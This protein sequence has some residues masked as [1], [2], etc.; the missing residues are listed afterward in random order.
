[1]EWKNT[2]IV[3]ISKVKNPLVPSNYRPISLCQTN[4]KIVASM[5]VN[6]L[7]KC[8][9][10]MISEE[11]M[12]FIPDRSISE[13]CL[14]AHEVF[15]KF[16]IS[17]NKKGLMA[18][19]LDM[20]QTYDSMGWPTLCQIL[21]WYGFPTFFSNVL[22]ECVVNVSSLKQRGQVLGIRVSHGVPKITHLLYADDVLVFSQV[23]L[24]I[25]KAL[26]VIVEDFCK[27]TGQRINA[28]KS[29]ILYGKAV[30]HHLKKKIARVIGFK[31]VK[32]MSYL[33]VRIYLNLLRMADFQELLSQVMERLNTWGK[34]SL[35]MGEALY[36]I[37][38]M[39][40][41]VCI[42][43]LGGEICKPRDI[44]GLGVHS[45]MLRIGSLRARLTCNYLHKPESLFHRTVRAKYGTDVMNGSHMKTSSSAWKILLDGGRN[46]R[47]VVKWKVGNDC[48]INV[49]KDV[50]LLDKCMDMWPT[51]AN[52]AALE[53]MIVQH[54]I[55]DGSWNYDLLQQ[56]FHTDLVLLISQIQIDSNRVEDQ[57]ELLSMFSGKTISA[58]SYEN[59]MKYRYPDDDDGYGNGLK[60]LKLNKKV[61]ISWWRLS[62]SAIPT[63]YFLKYRRI[64]FNDQCARG[65]QMFE[66]YE[67]IMV[68]CRY[69][70][71][72]IVKLRDWEITKAF[73]RANLT[74]PKGD[75]LK[76]DP[77]EDNPLEDEDFKMKCLAFKTCII[78]Y[79]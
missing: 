41:G 78:Q 40:R 36:G 67:H 62:K 48:K 14:L 65:C 10:T 30:R 49:L 59:L 71:D 45:P 25:A 34:K 3:L 15:H 70:V 5:L 2:L 46:L 32:E 52:C 9:S 44:G 24:A 39:G 38:L 57:L 54:L 60:K 31:V 55:S 53:D 66:D 23:S 16:K 27:W 26:K 56:L 75:D 12:A 35:P 73:W 22:M 11:Q 1:M 69:F 18:I 50:W 58:L 68:M 61:E 64:S 4:Y 74:K 37:N 79:D 21:K 63:N 76:D 17:K 28:S 42:M 19:K 33:G 72:T 47:N 51:F 6:R 29:Q 8:I 7:K 77:E 13:H 43:L 20:K